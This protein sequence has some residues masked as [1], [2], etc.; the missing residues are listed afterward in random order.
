MLLS[1]EPDFILTEVSWDRIPSLAVLETFMTISAGYTVPPKKMPSLS[2]LSKKGYKPAFTFRPEEYVIHKT[3]DVAKTKQLYEQNGFETE[4][5]MQDPFGHP[6][7][8]VACPIGF[9]FNLPEPFKELRRFNRWICRI[10]VD[11]C[12]HPDRRLVS[13]PHIEPDP[14]F[15]KLAH[16]WDT[17]IKG[18]VVRGEV[19]VKVLHFLGI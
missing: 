17:F 11:I 19:A 12:Q 15:H 3:E 13:V 9:P 7:P 10:H 4:V 1:K 14:G 8:T 18:N 16:L 5:L 2:A 6:G